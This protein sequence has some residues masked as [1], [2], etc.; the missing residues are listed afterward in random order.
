MSIPAATIPATASPA[1]SSEGK[2][3]SIVVR[4]GGATRSRSVAS[5][6]IPSVPC[7]PTNRWVSA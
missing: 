2:N 5:V 3:A 7:D 1:P 4:G 6:M